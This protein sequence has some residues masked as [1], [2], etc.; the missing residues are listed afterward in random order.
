MADIR[1]LERAKGH[2]VNLDADQR[3]SFLSLLDRLEASV[4]R[5]ISASRPTRPTLV[6]TDGACEP[7]GDNFVGSVGAVIVMPH[8][9]TF[10]MRAFGCYLPKCLMSEWAETGKKHLIGPVELYAVGLARKCWS[11]FLDNRALFFVDHGGVLAS[12]ISGSS[13]DAIWRRVLL[14]LEKEDSTNPCLSWFAR[15]ASPSNISD[16]PSRG[17][18]KDLSEFEY[19]RDY[20]PCF[21][22]GK[23]M[24][25]T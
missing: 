20:P 7:D 22:T 23:T 4:P 11:N 15:V 16:G 2:E 9:K 8:G 12:L 10:T 5:T 14:T 24:E 3:L 19:V 18:W 21:L 13:R 6:F 1:S 25:P 17:N